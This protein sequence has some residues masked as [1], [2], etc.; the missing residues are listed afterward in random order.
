MSMQFGAGEQLHHELGLEPD[1]FVS[2]RAPE[3]DQCFA[4]EVPALMRKLLQLWTI[5]N[6]DTS[7]G[8]ERLRF[9]LLVA[10]TSPFLLLSLKPEAGAEARENPV[11]TSLKG[12]R[13]RRVHSV[14]PHSGYACWR[15][16]PHHE[17]M[18][19]SA[20]GLL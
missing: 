1:A 20:P 6:T 4:I 12:E 15:F 3:K 7:D 8:I 19:V 10:H 17:W 18:R 13:L 5:A 14:M 9:G 11:Y 2:H 16:L